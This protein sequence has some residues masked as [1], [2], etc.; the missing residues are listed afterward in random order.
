MC[1][2]L[3]SRGRTKRTTLPGMMPRPS[4][5]PSS[6]CSNNACIPRHTPRK[7]RSAAIQSR[8]TAARP[9]ALSEATQSRK[10]PTPGNTSPR[11]LLAASSAGVRTTRGAAPTASNAL[12]TL[13]RLQMPLSMTAIEG[14]GTA[15]RLEASDME[16][17]PPLKS[18]PWCS[19]ADRRRA[20]RSASRRRGRGRAP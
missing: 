16:R 7:G 18:Y 17:K 4:M 20:I 1:G 15:A 11:A 8:A 6:E 2:I 9:E 10:A 19:A 5:S 13:R 3:N 12:V 14:G